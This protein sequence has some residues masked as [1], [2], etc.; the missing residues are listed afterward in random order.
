MRVLQLLRTN[1]KGN[2]CWCKIEDNGAVKVVKMR[3]E[4]AK[5][6]LALGGRDKIELEKDLVIAKMNRIIWVDRVR[7]LWR[8][9]KKRFA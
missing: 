8:R 5:E 9:L 4:K 7:Y 3:L 2:R 6:L 1:P